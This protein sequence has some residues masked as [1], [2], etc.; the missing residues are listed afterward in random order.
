MPLVG[1]RAASF[2]VS[3]Y[4]CGRVWPLNLYSL[5]CVAKAVPASADLSISHGTLR[6]G[7]RPWP[8]LGVYQ[9]LPTDRLE[10]FR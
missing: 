5:C 8:R 1:L 7:W 4:R 2:V 10:Q 9:K 3:A 6:R